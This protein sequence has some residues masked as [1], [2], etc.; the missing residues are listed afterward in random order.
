MNILVICEKVFNEVSKKKQPE[1]GD[2][3]SG[4]RIITIEKNNDK[5][6]YISGERQQDS[7]QTYLQIAQQRNIEVILIHK[8]KEEYNLENLKNTARN[9]NFDP[10]KIAGFHTTDDSVMNALKEQ[11]FELIKNEII[12][13]EIWKPIFSD[14]KHEI[15]NTLDPIR[16]NLSALINKNFSQEA[17]NS[18]GSTFNNIDEEF[19]KVKELVHSEKVESL[20]KLVKSKQA[21][22]DKLWK[23]I[24]KL[25]PRNNGYTGEEKV[26]KLLQYLGKE[27]NLMEVRKIVKVYGNVFEKWWKEFVDAIENL[28]NLF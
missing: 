27:K 16:I 21:E 6:Y 10:R 15:L 22:N 20:K 18:F 11:N 1:P 14:I 17:L 25:L 26:N 24:E 2:L 13:P 12:S 28:K 5:W 19:K 3:S 7:Y 8:E 4:K 23:R 9:L